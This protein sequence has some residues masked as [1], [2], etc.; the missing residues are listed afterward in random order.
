[1]MLGLMTEASDIHPEKPHLELIRGT[2]PQTG[3]DE[4]SGAPEFHEQQH[5]A[6]TANLVLGP[7]SSPRSFLT[8]EKQSINQ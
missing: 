2:P 7:K 8:W 4:A 1:M 6:Y 3:L 5:F